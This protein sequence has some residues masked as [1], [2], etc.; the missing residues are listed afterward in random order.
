M[1]FSRLRFTKN[2][3][4]IRKFPA[5][6]MFYEIFSLKIFRNVSQKPIVHCNRENS[7]GVK[8]IFIRA[9]AHTIFHKHFNSEYI[10]TKSINRSCE[11][12]MN[13]RSK[14]N[15]IFHSHF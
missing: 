5:V 10:F 3:H 9:T 6:G 15:N 7:A 11:T 2:K 1:E 14:K 13:L 4:S 8:S 12:K